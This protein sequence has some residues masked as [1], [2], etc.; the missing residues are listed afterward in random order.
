M[1]RG[2]LVSGVLLLGWSVAASAQDAQDALAPEPAPVSAPM[3]A[4]ADSTSGVVMEGRDPA[5]LKAFRETEKRFAARMTELQDDTKQFVDLR[6]SQERTKISQSSDGMLA[7]LSQL[8]DSHRAMAID[9][10][11]KFLREYPNAKYSSHVRF[12]LAD[13]YFEQ[14][15]EK[16]LKDSEAYSELEQKLGVEHMDE[17]PPEP[18]V[19]LSKSIALYERII[20]DNRD[21]PR[22][23]QYQPLDAVFYMLGFSYNEPQSAQHD[24]DKSKAAFDDLIAVRPD[25]DLADPAH[26]FIGNYWFDKN[27]FEEALAE[28]QQVVDKGPKSDYYTMA[29]YQLAWTYYKLA[30]PTEGPMS[31]GP[32][33][34]DKALNLFTTLIDQSAEELK[35]TGKESDFRPD[36]VKYVAI[37]F[38]DVSEFTPDSPMQVAQ[39][40]F[41][42]VGPRDWEPDVY[43]ALANVLETQARYDEAIAVYRKLQDDPRWVNRPENPDYQMR[44]VKLE[45]SKRPPDLEAS[46][47]AR[48]ALSERY[49]ENS[50]WWK[51]N[52]DHPDAQ[53]RARGYIESSLADIAIEYRL[54]ANRTGKREDYLASAKRF[55]A[56]LAKFPIADD[57]YQMQWYLADTLYRAGEYGDALKQ[58][59]SLI[60]SAKYHPYGDG[61]IYFSMDASL[62]RLQ[63]DQTPPAVPETALSAD[64]LKIA[65]DQGAPLWLVP[66]AD[67]VD[68]TYQAVAGKTMTVYKLSDDDKAFI[69]AADRLRKHHFAP[70]TSKEVTDFAKIFEARRHKVAYLEAQLLWFHNRYDE[71]RPRLNALIDEY[72]HKNEAAYAAGLLVDSYQREGDLDQVRLYTR[73]FMTMSLGEDKALTAQRKEQFESLLEGA[74]FKQALAYVDKGDRARAAESFIAFTEDFPKS[75]HVPAA[76]Y[77]AANSYELIGK[78]DKASALFEEYVQRYPD[79]ERSKALYFRIAAN[80]ES[81]FD[82]DKAV[83]YYEQ[84]V[85]RFPKDPDAADALYNA[86]FLKI[87]L[88]DHA[89]AARGFEQYATQF[90]D[91][92]DR[93]DVD[94]QAGEQW[95]QVSDTAAR[96]F[97]E[98][99]LKTYGLNNPDHALEAEEKLAELWKKAGSSRRERQYQQRI[100]ADY[101]R[102]AAAGKQLGWG[103]KHYAAKAAFVDVKA[104]HDK[105]VA[106]KL[107]GREDKDTALLMD[108]LPKELAELEKQALAMVHTYGD[109]EYSTAAL[110]VIA[111]GYLSYAD[112]GFSLKPPDSMS[113]EEQDVYWEILDTKVFPQFYAVQDKAVT[114]FQ[115]VIDLADQQQRYSKWVAKAHDGLN[116]LDPHKYPK[117]KPEIE[118]GVSAEITPKIEPMKPPA[119]PKPEPAPDPAPAPA[120]PAPAP[121]APTGGTP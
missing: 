66:R 73:K 56:Y 13:F 115:A 65:K 35:Q 2:L 29:V 18:K 69:T 62:Q 26:V 105:F 86:S 8:E 39:K 32:T 11:E 67:A 3:V 54:T 37:S 23:E 104:A 36:A 59:E 107:S 102:L 100:I 80:Y 94:F 70:P 75:E 15:K 61:A 9:E 101:G 97:Y 99:Y 53:S 57:Y 95:E 117:A 103:S 19:D 93:E 114:R 85:Q 98:R 42:K 21:L 88:G 12:R 50:T 120:A 111:D 28:Y 91:K 10:M 48:V 24:A 34:Y 121:A 74:A 110:Y 25:Y 7:T 22:D 43:V 51:A 33:A 81:T 40:Y 6:E 45:A 4:A 1:T 89:G 106:A 72:P 47:T 20:A 16:W 17:L 109:F 44:I 64:L 55:E 113:P 119:K 84:L 60:Q 14:A 108:A 87:G 92:A 78:A 112:L 31:L 116:A 118:G 30:G 52:D 68:N 38:F 27:K 5:E 82:L 77:N 96:H 63:Q 41:D 79:D 76:L 58:Y 46:A 71:A 49:D 83:S 90:P